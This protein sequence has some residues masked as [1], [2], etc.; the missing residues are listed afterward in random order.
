M[1]LSHNGC[2]RNFYTWQQARDAGLLPKNYLQCDNSCVFFQGSPPT[3]EVII[4]N[5][6]DDFPT[7]ASS[8]GSVGFAI[9]YPSGN[10]PSGYSDFKQVTITNTNNS[11]SVVISGSTMDDTILSNSTLLICA[12]VCPAF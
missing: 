10:W 5:A 9:A 1:M 7:N 11:Y 8:R 4:L 2:D 3:P 12:S 6:S